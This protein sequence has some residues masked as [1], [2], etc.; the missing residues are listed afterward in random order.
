MTTRGEI[1]SNFYQIVYVDANGAPTQVKPEYLP[2]VGNAVHANF[3]DVANSVSVGNVVGIGNIATINLDNSSSN[4]LFGNGIWAPASYSAVANYAN[5]AGNLVVLGNES[6]VY[7]RTANTYIESHTQSGNTYTQQYQDSNHWEVFPEDDTTGPNPTWAWINASLNNGNPYVIIENVPIDTGIAKTWKFD[8]QGNLTLP[9]N[10]FSVNYANGTQVSLGGD[11]NYAN[12]AGNVV[13]ASQGN[14]TSLGTLVSLDVTGNISSGNANLGNL[15]T[16]NYFSGSGNLLSNIQLANINGIG[17]IASINLDGSSSN[18]LYGNGVWSPIVI[19]TGNGISNGTSN[20]SIPTANGNV[21]TSVGGVANVFVVTT[22]GANVT[23][24]LYTTANIT[25]NSLQL[26]TG[27]GVTTANVGQMFWDT[28]EQTVTLGMNNGVQQQ[29]GLESYILVKAGSTITDGQVVMYSGNSSGN[30]VIGVPADVTAV[31]FRPSWVLGIATQ[32][33]A[34][35]GTGYITTFGHVHGLNTN[36]Y[37]EGDLL[38]LSTST[39]GAFTST[40]PT[41]PNWHIQVGTVVKK[42]GGAGVVQ[43]AVVV[44]DKVGNLSDVTL[45]TPTAGQALIYTSSNTWINGNSNYANTA[46]TVVT[47]AQP[48]ITSTGTL[49]STTFAANA[50][51]LMSGTLSR[52]SG[53]NLLSASYL[54]GTLTTG[55]QPNITSTGTLTSLTVTGNISSG[56]ANLG[57]LTTSNY[58]SGNGSLLTAITAANISGT[59]ANANYAAYAGNVTIAA[60]AN[61]TSTGTLASL[62]VSGTANLNSTSNVANLVLNKYNELLPASA[63]TSTSISPD[64]STGSI[65]KYTANASFTFNALTNA[66]SGSSAVVVITQDGTGGRTLTSTMLFAGASKTLSTAAAAV[67]IISVFYDGTNYYATLSKGY[68]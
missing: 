42:S 4:V 56:N 66:V 7:V 47:G 8:A 35:N 68:A 36:A 27:T 44:N 9:A 49:A 61:I 52:V 63:N 17:N 51:I 28:T 40:E 41:A 57:N 1:N 38:F 22:T 14:I 45:T 37:N 19:P 48:N 43:V 33:I 23:G 34:T 10:T 6:N 18:V 15:T 54:T 53:A 62:I 11:A 64:L 12:Y 58:F 29:I 24:N 13:N 26:N 5:F 55:A 30:N 39:P 67:D 60:Q 20:V 25:G 46:G 31:G 21:N 65:F 59:V 16:S 32:N 2:E 3:A 50:N